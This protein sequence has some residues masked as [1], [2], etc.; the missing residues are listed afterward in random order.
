MTREMDGAGCF[1]KKSTPYPAKTFKR[2]TFPRKKGL[3][4]EHAACICVLRSKTG[5]KG[6]SRPHF[7]M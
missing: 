3:S 4:H 1:L 2:D 7:M 5:E 6:I